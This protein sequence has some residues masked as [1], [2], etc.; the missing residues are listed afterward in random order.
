MSPSIS[1][2]QLW[3]NGRTLVFGKREVLVRLQLSALVYEGDENWVT[4]SLKN[5]KVD[6]YRQLLAYGVRAYAG[7]HYHID[8]P[9]F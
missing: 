6:Y 4:H 2:L 9:N 3:S 1:Y 7:N 8:N 5:A